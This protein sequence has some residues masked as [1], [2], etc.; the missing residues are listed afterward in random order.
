MN[1]TAVVQGAVSAE[2]QAYKQAF[3]KQ[4]NEY[5]GR[6]PAI[7]RGTH[8]A[9]RIV[10]LLLFA[11]PVI[12][13]FVAMVQ[14]FLWATTGSFTSLGE[15]TSLPVAW[16]NFGLSMS[17]LVFPWGLDVMLLRAYPSETLPNWR[18]PRKAIQFITGVGAFFAGLGIACAGAPGAGRMI[19]LV[20]EAIR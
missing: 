11:L 3:L 15:A 17:F 7:V 2:E 14:T 5:L 10:S 1:S 18:K 6:Q 16:A 13:F 19:Q 8:Q 4:F 12:F 9:L 20:S